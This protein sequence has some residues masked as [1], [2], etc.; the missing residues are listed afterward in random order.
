MHPVPYPH[1]HI[2]TDLQQYLV[3]W[4]VNAEFSEHTCDGILIRNV[5]YSTLYPGHSVGGQGV[6]SSRVYKQSWKGEPLWPPTGVSDG[7]GRLWVSWNGATEVNMWAV[8][9]ADTEEILGSAAGSSRAQDGP[10]EVPPFEPW[11]K[12]KRGGFETSIDLGQS[13]PAFAK[14]VA[15]NQASEVIGCTKT[16]WMGNDVSLRYKN[17][18]SYIMLGRL[19]V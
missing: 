8:Y 19:L 4:G 7:N 17:S 16:V 15:L 6:A 18:I 11:Y 3:S 9:G 1:D 5:Q 12:V 13:R 2:S 10:I 14:V